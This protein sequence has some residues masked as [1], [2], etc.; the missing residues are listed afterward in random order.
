MSDLLDQL[1]SGTL[2]NVDGGAPLSVPTRVV[3]IER[4]L[5]GVE[6]ELLRGLD[7]GNRLA[8][9]S[10]RTTRDVLGER[11]EQAVSSFAELVSVVLP[12]R[13]HADTATA[14]VI[15]EATRDAD[16][17]IAVGSGTIND[18]CKIVSAKADKPY[19][20]F[21]TAPSMNGY[22]SV[23]AAITEHGHKKSLAAQGAAGV[24]IDLEIFAAAPH[25]MIRSGFGDSL[26]RP[27]A[28]TDW[29]LAHHALGRPYRHAPFALLA[30]DEAAL[31]AEPEGLLR[32]DLDAM[33]RLARTLTM[34]GFGMTICGGSYPA[35]Q[36]EHLIGHYIDMLGDPAWPAAFHGEQIAVTTLTMA[37]LQED[38]VSRPAPT[39]RPSSLGPADF[40]ARFGSETGPSCWAEFSKKQLDA[41]AA[42]ALNARLADAWPAITREVE[43]IAIPAARLRDALKKIGGPTECADLG[44][45]ADFYRAAVIHAREI[46]DRYT[47][48]DLAADSGRFDG[49]FNP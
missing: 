30:E 16:A 44:I 41:P 20:V 17:L 27:T 24:F 9:V 26:C 13:P 38:I 15:A 40:D 39:L 25:R 34:S 14:A 49:A 48:L 6:A 10:D 36:G 31:F 3:V 28:Q 21:A 5:A 29:L 37:R 12:D 7:L 45:P 35:S 1:L 23:N 32:G 22:S 19:A 11:V 43:R 46:R 42:E 4:S 8:V 33:A 2:A 47:F 18:L